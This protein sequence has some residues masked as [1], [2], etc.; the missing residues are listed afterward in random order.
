M[1]IVRELG[2]IGAVRSRSVVAI[3]N[4]DG[5]HLGHQRLLRSVVDAARRLDALSAVVTFDPHPT[6]VLVP[7]RAPKLLTPLNMKVRLIEQQGIELLVVLPFTLAL[8]RLSPVDFVR[9]VLCDNL[10]AASVHVGPNFRFG[11]RQAGNIAVLSGIAHELRFRVEVLPEVEVRGERVSSSRIRELLSQGKVVPAGRLLGRP[12]SI[13]ERIVHGLGVGKKLTVPTL[14]LAP[15]AVQ[16]PRNGVYVTYT[17]LGGELH[18]SVTNVGHKPTFGEHRLT[19][20]SYLLNFQGE[21][22]DE[23]MEV[24]FLHRL[25]DEMKFPDAATLK[26]Q[27]QKD[28]R[29]SLKYFRLIKELRQRTPMFMDDAN[30]LEN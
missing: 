13:E 25:R 1:R 3:G 20:E 14:N 29:R 12:Y 22:R 30:V 18:E 21:V 15:V 27:I 11:Y 19:V 4:F 23:E 7:D 17:C 5:V 26:A 2:E 16:H 10:N 8:S 28:A 24:Q 6:L 9:Q